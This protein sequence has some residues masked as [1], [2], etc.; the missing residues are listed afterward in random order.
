MNNFTPRLVSWNL[1][2]RCNLHCAHCYLNAGMR[3]SGDGELTTR[4]CLGFIDQ[5]ADYCHEAMLVFTGGEPL[6]RSDLPE[7]IAHSSS[8]GLMPVLGTNGVLLTGERVKQL[9]GSGLSGVGISLDSLAPRQHD[10]FRGLPGAWHK[11]V[12]G[13]ETSLKHGLAVQIH[14]TATRANYTEIPDLIAFAAERGAVAFNLFFLVCTGRGEQMIDISPTEYET[15]LEHLMDAQVK[16]EG[17]LMIRARCAPHFRRIAHM[18]NPELTISASGCLAGTS[19]CRLSPEGEVTPCPYLPISA[20]NLRS[21][22]LAHI[23][24]TAPLFMKLRHPTLRGRCGE[25]EFSVLCGGCR[26]RAFAA[27]GDIMAEDP[28]CEYQ[29]GN[30]KNIPYSPE[31]I[32][33]DSSLEWSVEAHARLA[34]VPAVLRP[35]V[36]KGVEAYARSQNLPIITPELM[37]KLRAKGSKTMH[38]RR[39]GHPKN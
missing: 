15:A 34:R 22:S 13:I 30:A 29:P 24:E 39:T 21:E 32:D 35:M 27:E 9:V 5:L 14:T 38:A 7:L 12:A 3:A 36:K 37:A 4:E 8:R 10:T 20:G 18:S 23:W 11:T 26:A 19:Y 25:C 16:Y 17:R 33:L 6:L 28:W 2:R 1:T 31:S